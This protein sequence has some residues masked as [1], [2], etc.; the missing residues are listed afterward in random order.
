MDN[1]IKFE[2]TYKTAECVSIWKYDLSK[3]TNGPISVEHKWNQEYLKEIALK[4]KRGR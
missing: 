1:K 3:F 2:R 4:Q